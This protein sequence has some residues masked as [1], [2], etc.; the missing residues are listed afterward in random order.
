MW[1]SVTHFA[2]VQ[3]FF[4]PYEQEISTQTSKEPTW[5][6]DVFTKFHIVEPKTHATSTSQ[7]LWY[8]LN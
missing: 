6:P 8:H 1:Q 3:A 4:T 2:H 7:V 5:R